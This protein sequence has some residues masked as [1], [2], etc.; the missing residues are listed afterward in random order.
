MILNQLSNDINNQKRA[1]SS[2]KASEHNFVDI[3][4]FNRSHD[5]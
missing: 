4:K 2:Q 1:D 5:V 3:S